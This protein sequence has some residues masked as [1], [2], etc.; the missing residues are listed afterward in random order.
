MVG[1]VEKTIKRIVSGRIHKRAGFLRWF[2]AVSGLMEI[3]PAKFPLFNF[4]HF[5]A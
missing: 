1:M 3:S 4:N 5:L 2:E